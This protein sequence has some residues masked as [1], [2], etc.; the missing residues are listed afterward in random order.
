MGVWLPIGKNFK[1]WSNALQPAP[2][3]HLRL[4]SR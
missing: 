2:A 1:T 4:L 3:L